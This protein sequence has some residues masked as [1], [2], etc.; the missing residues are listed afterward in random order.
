MT[1]LQRLFL[2]AGGPEGGNPLSM[3]VMMGLVMVVFYFFMIRPQTK[4]AKEQK[5]FLDSLKKGDK[6][7]TIGGIHGKILKVNDDSLLIEVD[8]N[9]KLKIERTAVSH[10]YTKAVTANNNNNG[11]S[12]NNKREELVETTE[13]K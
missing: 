3:L 8:A 9:T 11:N 7:V 6:V 2:M 5:S 4:K 12:G 13:E 10:D 1:E